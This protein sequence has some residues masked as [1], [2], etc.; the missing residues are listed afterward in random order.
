MNTFMKTMNQVNNFAYTENHALT[1][2]TTGSKVMDLFG[3]GAAYRKRSDEDCILLFKNAY[4]EDPLLALKCLFYISDCRGGQGERRFFRVVFKWLC[5][6]YPEVALKNLEQI[7]VYRR[8]DDLIYATEGTRLEEPAFTLIKYQLNLDMQSKTP[9]LCAKWMPSQNASSKETKRLGYKLANFLK[10]TS[11][12]YR[13]TLSILRERIKVLETLMSQNRWDE[14]EFDKIPS[15]AGLIYK[16]AFAH[17]EVTAARY[18]AF[19]ES[20]ATKVNAGTL[21]PYEIVAKAIN[22][23]SN[24]GWNYNNNDL[25][26]VDRQALEKY[27]EN[28]PEYFKDCPEQNMLC[29]V[30]TSGSMCGSEASA[31][32]NVAIS[33]GMYAAE[34]AGGPFKNCYISFSSRPQLINIEG[35]DFVDKVRRIYRTNLCENTNLVATFD[36]LLAIADRP[37]V[38]E[39]DVPNSI[40]VISDMEI[41]SASYSYN[42]HGW[43]K[44]NMATEMERVRQKWIKHGHKPPRLT[45]WNVQARHNNILDL[46]PNVSYVS[47]M[48]PSIFTQI[49]TGKSGWDL[50]VETLMSDRY[51][52]IKI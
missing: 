20:K 52:A 17:K 14:I 30:D 15:K 51:A 37:D 33:L 38:K 46:G 23:T 1:H 21:Y 5:K 18:K 3:L 50:M 16:N 9:S 42:Y 7:P 32:I 47:G 40:V 41:D 13:K 6:N 48:S 28:L 26:A 19:M 34:R 29:V 45:Y 8:W 43:T 4:E 24:W 49:M 27:W 31:P 39:E 10:M 35:V 11:K 22:R 12:E 25:S 2:K 36:M 44:D